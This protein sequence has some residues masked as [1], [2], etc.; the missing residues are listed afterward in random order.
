LRILLANPDVRPSAL[1]VPGGGDLFQQAHVYLTV[2]APDPSRALGDFWT[3]MRVPWRPAISL[4]VTAPLDLL[5]EDEPAPALT[6]FVQHYRHIDSTAASEERIQFGGWVVRL[7]DDGPVANAVVELLGAGGVVIGTATTDAAG[8]F[9]FADLR[10]GPVEF[11]A[12]APGFAPVT[13]VLLLPDATADEHL[14]RM[15]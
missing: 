9:E 6:T 7:S 5:V 4:V 8:R 12:S 3:S 1:P 13:R 14:F 11:R 10:R 2:A 15:S